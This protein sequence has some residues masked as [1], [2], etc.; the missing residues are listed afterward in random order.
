MGKLNCKVQGLSYEEFMEFFPP[1]IIKDLRFF[2]CLFVFDLT[3]C[4]LWIIM[5][6]RNNVASKV[7]D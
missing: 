1:H 3:Y 2:V 7:Y 6:R 5:A 4:M